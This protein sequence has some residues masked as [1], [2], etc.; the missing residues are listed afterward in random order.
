MMPRSP[1]NNTFIT[2]WGAL[3]APLFR[4]I[5]LTFVTLVGFNAI[6]VL[7]TIISPSQHDV[8]YANTASMVDISRRQDL[9]PEEK[10]TIAIFRHNNPSVVYISTVQRVLNMWTRDISEV[11]QWNWNRFFMG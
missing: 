8:L 6:W 3:M 11:P 2:Q 10:G 7:N 1:F 4:F 5:A 9:T